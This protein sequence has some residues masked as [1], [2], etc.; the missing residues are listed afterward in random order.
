MIAYGRTQ[1]I[2]IIAASISE[3]VVDFIGTRGC[4]AI[5]QH[6]GFQRQLVLVELVA[7]EQAVLFNPFPARKSSP[8][9]FLLS[10]LANHNLDALAA[11]AEKQLGMAMT[12]R[13]WRTIS[14]L[15][16]LANA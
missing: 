13:N 2:K 1:E 4:R 14:K 16:E 12:S 8:I 7:R 3:L 9:A 11:Q 10:A 15:M 5:K 6:Q